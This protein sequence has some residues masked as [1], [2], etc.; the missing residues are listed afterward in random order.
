M[1]NIFSL[2]LTIV[3]FIIWGQITD[4]LPVNSENYKVYE[5]GISKAFIDNK[6]P[7]KNLIERLNSNWRLEET[8]KGYW[9]GYTDDMYSIAAHKNAAIKP[10][11][12]FIKYAKNS[13]SKLGAVY[14]LHLIGIDSKIVGRFYEKFVNAKARQALLSLIYQPELTDLVIS[15][16]AR[17]PWKT[18]LPKLTFYLKHYPLNLTLINSLFR[19]EKEKAPFRQDIN[20]NIDTL[21]V[22]LKDS[23]GLHSIGTL[24]IVHKEKMDDISVDSKSNTML[25]SVYRY[26]YANS[27]NYSLLEKN[28]NCKGP[29]I[30]S[31]ICE[32]LNQQLYDLLLLSEEKVSVFSYCDLK[33]RFHHY[34][35]NGRIIVICTPD[36]SLERWREFYAKK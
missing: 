33:D 18:D 19:Y 2:I 20:K 15:L 27:W 13:H 34:V 6:T 25:V 26:F 23:K 4:T 12:N 7:L 9:I 31:G 3:P 22:F 16:L 36:Q 10:L 11:L 35:I 28:F 1:K 14:C 30:D 17:D 21:P 8:G 5:G 32:E 29:Q 24:V